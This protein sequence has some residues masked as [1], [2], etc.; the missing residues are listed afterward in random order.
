MKAQIRV[1]L[2]ATIALLPPG[3]RT[4][5]AQGEVPLTP[6]KAFTMAKPG[7]WV[8][9]EGTPQKGGHVICTKVKLLTG[10]IDE[11]DWAVR[12]SIQGIDQTK[13]ELTVGRY[14]IRLDRQPKFGSALGTLKSFAD[15]RVGMF[16]KVEGTFQKDG[17]FLARKV[18]DEAEQ[19]AKKPGVAKSIRVQGKIEHAD[20]A[21]R[22]IT[23]MATRFL[24]GD[25]A[26]IKS[27]VK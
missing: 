23:V 6:A 5:G 16:V 2:I 20:P 21:G 19:V 26:Q 4:A 12:G 13:R 18:N 11:N 3:L 22:T 14:R 25:Q 7:Q 10:A 17:I 27:V 1:L 15:L 8:V 24:V 9:L